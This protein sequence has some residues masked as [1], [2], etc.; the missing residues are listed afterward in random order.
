[1]QSIRLM[2]GETTMSKPK[3]YCTPW[4]AGLQ[5]TSREVGRRIAKALD[6]L[7]M[8][9][10]WVVEGGEG[11]IEDEFWEFRVKVAEKLRAEGWRISTPK[12]KYRVL[13]PKERA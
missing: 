12:N 5:S 11:T 3:K 8:I 2:H 4:E 7:S 13:P 9:N 10:S 6:A 1:M